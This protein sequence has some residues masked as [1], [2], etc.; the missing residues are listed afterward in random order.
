MKTKILFFCTVLFLAHQMAFAQRDTIRVA[1]IEDLPIIHE[2][3]GQHSLTLT[4]FMGLTYH[5]PEGFTEKPVRETVRF[6]EN[7]ILDGTF[8]FLM[9]PRGQLQS[10]DGEM[11]AFFNVLNHDH[12]LPRFNPY[13]P[14]V[15]RC[16]GIGHVATIREAYNE[17]H[18]SKALAQGLIERPAR[19]ILRPLQLDW[20]ESA[21][22][23]SS[24]EARSK[25]NADTAFFLTL[26]LPPGYYYQDKFGYMD[27]FGLQKNGRGFIYIYSFYTEAAMQNIECYRRRL[28][29]S[30]HF[31]EEHPPYI[32]D[33]ETERR[34]AQQA[35]RWMAWEV[36]PIIHPWLGA[37]GV[38]SRR[39]THDIRLN[40]QIPEGFIAVGGNE[41]FEEYPLLRRAFG[42]RPGRVQSDDN[43]HFSL[44]E[45]TSFDMLRVDAFH[46][47]RMRGIYN[48]FH[49]HLQ[50]NY[51]RD[52][53]QW[54][55][56]GLNNDFQLDW[57]ESAYFFSP[58]ETREKFNADIA[59]FFTL[60]LPSGYYYLEK[61]R[62]IDVFLLQKYG[63]GSVI[64]VSF[65]TETA[66]QNIDW[67]RQR[68][69]G[70][71]RYED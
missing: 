48:H 30:V 12:F 18:T 45:I 22:F 17:F 9:R 42:C 52:S 71:L 36:T 41:C 69:W 11:V 70:S 31:A 37:F 28:W 49:H 55:S 64:L 27:V 56:W 8:F 38:E 29:D 61:Y 24:E 16:I 34:I 20:R 47:N 33:E 32:L 25:F 19:G 39:L 43:E 51:G 35:E 57:R 40:F 1:T 65:Y 26:R 7:R 10:D 46:Q 58:E 62:Y 3:L 13:V 54:Q 21:N 63:R 67:Y 15:P 2:W 4:H 14:E 68:L 5:T 53:T 60:T 44:F 23:F 66:K 59:T 6:F 50:F